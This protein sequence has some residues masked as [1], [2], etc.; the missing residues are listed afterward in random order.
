MGLTAV[1]LIYSPAGKRSGAHMNPAIT[2]GFLRLAKIQP[3]DAL[4]YM[5]GQFIGGAVGVFISALLL[6]HKVI[7]DAAVNYIVTIPG[8]WG[9]GVAWL[10]E[11]AISFLLMGTVLLVNQFPKLSRFTG[12]F[13]GALIVLFV[14]F[15]APISGFGMNPART[16]GSAIMANIWTAGWIYFT[17]PVLGMLAGI[18]IHHIFIAEYHLLCPR[19]NHSSHGDKIHP[20]V[21]LAK[22]DGNRD[23]SING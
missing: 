9:T 22:G 3:W 17:A 19:L 4:F 16:F 11:F 5:A 2:L 18:E 8:I 14:M 12:W 7:A 21:C 1:V 20:C 13:A 10:A 15:E 23:N 6:G